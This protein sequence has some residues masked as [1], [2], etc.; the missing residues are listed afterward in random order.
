MA[1]GFA[2]DSIAGDLPSFKTLSASMNAKRTLDRS[3]RDA[4]NDKEES[5]NGSGSGGGGG[6]AG[7]SGGGGDGED[8]PSSTHAR[9]GNFQHFHHNHDDRFSPDVSSSQDINSSFDGR[10]NNNNSRN[11][12]SFNFSGNGANH[13]GSNGV[14]V[15]TPPPTS[16]KIVGRLSPPTG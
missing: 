7:R 1:A 12:S 8:S 3:L 14:D 13:R 11:G 6:S 9:S 16:R 15:N 4:L 5:F 10:N 2:S